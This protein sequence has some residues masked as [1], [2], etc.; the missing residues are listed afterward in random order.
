MMTTSG[1]PPDE[2]IDLRCGSPQIEGRDNNLRVPGS[3]TNSS[4]DGYH[5][6]DRKEL[7]EKERNKELIKES[8]VAGKRHQNKVS[9]SCNNN[10]LIDKND[11]DYFINTNNFELLELGELTGGGN[12]RST[13][14]LS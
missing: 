9:L 1:T 11:Y 10:D 13:T 8:Y 5:Y 4:V 14:L 12:V 7:E 6:G 2:I 3:P